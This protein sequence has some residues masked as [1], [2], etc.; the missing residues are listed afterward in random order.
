MATPDKVKNT[1]RIIYRSNDK[2]NYSG[3]SSKAARSQI[4]WNERL[5]VLSSKCNISH[6]TWIEA[7]TFKIFC[8]HKKAVNL[9]LEISL[10]HVVFE[11]SSMEPSK[12]SLTKIKPE[13][14]ENNQNWRKWTSWKNANLF[15]ISISHID[16]STEES[17]RPLCLQ[18][19][20]KAQRNCL[21]SP[22]RT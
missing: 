11:F 1:Q 22:F 16:D 13:K 17:V 6:T 21:V 3:Y 7:I 9:H 18:S 5:I 10:Y 4:E 8:A 20:S 2:T 12:T 14:C 15:H 19:G